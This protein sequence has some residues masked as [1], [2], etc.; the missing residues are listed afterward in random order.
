[1]ASKEKESTRTLSNATVQIAMIN[2]EPE[3][4]GRR[5]E[6]RGRRTEDGAVREW[7]VGGKWD[8]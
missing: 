3:E 7:D 1:M 4:G 6:V 8:A 2:A 5:S